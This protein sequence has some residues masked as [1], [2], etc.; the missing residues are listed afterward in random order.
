MLESGLVSAGVVGADE[1][2]WLTSAEKGSLKT[3][4]GGRLR[5]LTV[6]VK[7]SSGLPSGHLAERLGDV[8]LRQRPVPPEF[9]HVLARRH[10]Q[11]GE[12]VRLTAG[13]VGQ[14]KVPHV[15]LVISLQRYPTLRP[16]DGHAPTA[17]CLVLP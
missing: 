15:S 11:L 17:T 10:R 1:A 9:L 12:P 2:F 8:V 14:L 6:G 16:E 7:T 4:L 13:H 3:K 5:S